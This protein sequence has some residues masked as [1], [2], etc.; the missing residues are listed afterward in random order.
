MSIPEITVAALAEAQGRFLLVEE[1]IDGRL[2][3]N[4][5]AGHLERG[6]TLHEAIVREVREE[7]AWKFTPERLLGVYL[8]CHPRTRRLYKRFAFT[9]T[10]SDHHAHQR[11]DSGIVAARWLTPQEIRARHG[12]LRSPLVLRCLE[13]YLAGLRAPLEPI[14]RLDFDGALAVPSVEV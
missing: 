4:Q 12:E 14:A 7:S 3:L 9:G 5:P 11:L 10:V 6:E 8:W 1:R 13:D 2:V